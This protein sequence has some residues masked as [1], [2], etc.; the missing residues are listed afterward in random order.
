MQRVV[1]VGPGAAGKST[2][3]VSLGELTGLPVV[4]LDKLFWRAGLPQR[5][6]TG[7]Q[8]TSASSSGMSRGSWTETWGPMTSSMSGCR[9]R[10]PSCSWTSRYFAAPGVRSGGRGNELISGGDCLPTGAGA[11]RCSRGRSPCMLVTPISMSSRPRVQSGSFSRRQPAAAQICL[12]GPGESWPRTWTPLQVRPR[13][14]RDSRHERMSFVNRLWVMRITRWRN[15]LRRH[16]GRKIHAHDPAARIFLFARPA[17]RL[18][19]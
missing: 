8:L 6:Q 12:D 14:G 13:Q 11:V 2:L 9:L 5:S 7:G 17:I 3:A 4:E 1:I 19:I 16:C 18:M 15:H 10:T